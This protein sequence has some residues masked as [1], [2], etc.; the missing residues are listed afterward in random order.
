MGICG[1]SCALCVGFSASNDSG[2]ETPD[3]S[4]S[5]H[6][7]GMANSTDVVRN[8]GCCTLKVYSS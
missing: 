1:L 4:Y 7:S 5:D 8:D 6:T 3:T 2:D